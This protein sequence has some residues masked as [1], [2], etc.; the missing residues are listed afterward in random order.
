MMENDE[1]Y[2]FKKNRLGLR[3]RIM[4]VVVAFAGIVYAG[5]AILLSGIKAGAT[6][7]PRLLSTGSIMA[8]G[9]IGICL[10]V[11]GIV[12]LVLPAKPML[13]GVVRAISI[14]V[15][16][17]CALMLLV[18]FTSSESLTLAFGGVGA[19]MCGGILPLIR[20]GRAR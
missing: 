10:T 6:N 4:G 20:E 3:L 13:T 1:E 5:C 15:L 7:N 9:A 2:D 14:I 16:V 17:A 8:I 19:A 11:L 12:M 18:S